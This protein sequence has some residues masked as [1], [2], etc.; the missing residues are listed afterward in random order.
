M[1]RDLDL[2][3]ELLLEVEKAEKPLTLDDLETPA[4]L[5]IHSQQKI[6]YH[7][8]LLHSA[9][10]VDASI[11]YADNEVYTATIKGLTWDGQDFLDV[12]REPNVFKQAKQA[13]NEAVGSTTFE[14]VKQTCTVVATSLIKQNL[15]L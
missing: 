3:R 10:L 1:K 8:W 4:R 13:I 11:F 15:G 9:G 14:V 7:I 12:M 6:R 5:A 2:V